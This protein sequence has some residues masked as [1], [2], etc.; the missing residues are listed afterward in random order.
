[1]SIFFSQKG[2]DSLNRQLPSNCLPS[3]TSCTQVY[4]TTGCKGTG[5]TASIQQFQC[6]Q[7]FYEKQ[8]VA[9]QA[10]STKSQSDASSS[11]LQQENIDIKSQLQ[12]LQQEI[13]AQKAL[14]LHTSP[15]I[16]I[17]TGASLIAG[18]FIGV[19]IHRF[20]IKNDK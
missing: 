18:I 7:L 5:T 15:P 9:Q 10:I 20:L 14:S 13:E 17:L 4:I 6:A 8:Q 16:N 12:T 19:V 3:D 2:L 11:L 1:M